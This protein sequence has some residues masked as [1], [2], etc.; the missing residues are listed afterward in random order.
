ME[1][2]LHFDDNA[3]DGRV[4]GVGGDKE[5]AEDA[6]VGPFDIEDWTAEDAAEERHNKTTSRLRLGEVRL[7]IAAA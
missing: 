3:A 7:S 5:V 6:D 2:P 4:S 1:P